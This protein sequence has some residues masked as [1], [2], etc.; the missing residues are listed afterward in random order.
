M[1]RLKSYPN[2]PSLLDGE[3]P[4]GLK[5][6]TRYGNK[7]WCPGEIPTRHGSCITVIE[8]FDEKG[9]PYGEFMGVQKPMTRGFGYSPVQ[10]VDVEGRETSVKQKKKKKK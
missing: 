10:I 1:S 6:Q 9:M 5:K 8:A 4:R 3:P 2:V 7:P